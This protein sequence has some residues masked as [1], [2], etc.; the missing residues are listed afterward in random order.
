[1][2]ADG[3]LREIAT[4]KPGDVIMGF[5]QATMRAVPRTVER[6]M[7]HPTED[8]A[9]GTVVLNGSI[10]ATR[11]HPFLSNGQAVRADVL[12]VGDVVHVALSRGGR[13]TIVEKTITSVTT[14]EGG[15]PSF[16]LKTSPPGGYIVGKDQTVALQKILP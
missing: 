9:T 11:N 16:D 7:I 12:R 14:L 2:M 5:D 6:L 1:M 15:I 13:M 10:R 3:T 4:I 8:S